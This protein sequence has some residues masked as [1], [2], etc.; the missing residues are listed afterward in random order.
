MVPMKYHVYIWL[1]A[2]SRQLSTSI[3]LPDHAMDLSNSELNGLIRTQV[4]PLIALKDYRIDGLR[5]HDALPPPPPPAWL[6]YEETKNAFPNHHPIFGD[7]LHYQW[8]EFLGSLLGK[9][10]ASARDWTLGPD[11]LG[12]PTFPD[13]IEE[14]YVPYRKA[15]V[16]WVD[17]ISTPWILMPN[18]GHGH[19][20]MCHPT[21]AIPNLSRFISPRP[22]KPLFSAKTHPSFYVALYE[23]WAYLQALP[24]WAYLPS[25]GVVTD[26]RYDAKWTPETML[27]LGATASTFRWGWWSMLNHAFPANSRALDFLLRH[28]P[29]AHSDG[30]INPSPMGMEL[31][32]EF[33]TVPP[34]LRIFIDPLGR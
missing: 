20:G 19:L 13:K 30:S 18:M 21:I 25:I 23:F 4:D 33:C 10:W 12:H 22:G 16:H 27:C 32:P 29:K 24:L 11:G 5:E 2:L 26:N 6:A 28:Y 1:E 7:H 3:D 8:S 17:E 9:T 34:K 15:R 14:G 31:N